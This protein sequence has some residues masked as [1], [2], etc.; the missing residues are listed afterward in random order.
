MGRGQAPSSISFQYKSWSSCSNYMKNRI[1]LLLVGSNCCS[2]A[3]IVT[4]RL[5]LFVSVE[6]L[7]DGVDPYKN[8]VYP[9]TLNWA[10]GWIPLA[11]MGVLAPVSAHAGHSAQPPMALAE[12]FWHPCLQSRFHQISPFSGQNRVNW[13]CRGDSPNIF[14]IGFLILFLLRSPWKISKL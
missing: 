5:Q 1:Q 3:P 10:V 11:P 9:Q 8:V 7:V 12:I 4:R 6:F 2:V 14:F 13:G